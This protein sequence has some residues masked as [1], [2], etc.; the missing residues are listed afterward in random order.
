MPNTFR[1]LHAK[2]RVQ[3]YETHSRSHKCIPTITYNCYCTV[4]YCE[5][6]WHKIQVNGGQSPHNLWHTVQIKINHGVASSNYIVR[7]TLYEFNL[8]LKKV[9]DGVVKS[10]KN[11]IKFNKT[12]IANVL[13]S[14]WLWRKFWHGLK[15]HM[16]YNNT[17]QVFK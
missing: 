13:W 6:I 4:M 14:F 8:S 3:V 7:H 5:S 12:K 15:L 10:N 2:V 17:Y 16:T 9:I 1:N 11:R